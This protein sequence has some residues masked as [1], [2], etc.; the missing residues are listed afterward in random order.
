MT[1]ITKTSNAPGRPAVDESRQGHF[2]DD[3][4]HRL[5]VACDN[6]LPSGTAVHLTLF[7]LERLSRRWLP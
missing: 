2:C 4:S 7:G 3:A 5:T 6:L 1:A